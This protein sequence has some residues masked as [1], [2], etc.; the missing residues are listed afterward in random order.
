M[1][2]VSEIAA[3]AHNQSVSGLFARYFGAVCKAS[4]DIKVFENP[5][6]TVITDSCI[7]NT[8]TIHLAT[9]MSMLLICHF[10]RDNPAVGEN[11]TTNCSW[12]IISRFFPYKLHCTVYVYV[13]IADLY[14]LNQYSQHYRLFIRT[15]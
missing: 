6:S 4:S 1:L 12:A 3:L 8:H 9:S 11:E 14:T 10:V 7:S 15:L 5:F 13:Q 2:V